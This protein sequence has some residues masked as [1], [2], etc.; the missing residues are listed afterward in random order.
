MNLNG[1]FY[2]GAKLERKTTRVA[3]IASFL[4]KNALLSLAFVV[5]LATA[6]SFG[7]RAI[8]DTRRWDPDRPVAIA[9][10]MTNRYIRMTWRVPP[11]IMDQELGLPRT[12]DG[13]MTLSAIA[14]ERGVPVEDLVAEVEAA[15]KAF[16][17]QRK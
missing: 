12:G 6:I 11:R 14:Q 7:V 16:T 15:L 9:P 3:K 13:P 8:D 10:W 5:L 1:A 2:G 4:R 17:E